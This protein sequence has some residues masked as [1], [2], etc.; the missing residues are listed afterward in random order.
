MISRRGLFK[1]ATGSTFGVVLSDLFIDGR[2]T[3][4]PEAAI[5]SGWVG[6]SDPFGSGTEAHGATIYDLRK[7]EY[8]VTLLHAE[9]ETRYAVYLVELRPPEAPDGTPLDWDAWGGADTGALD[10]DDAKFLHLGDIRTNGRGDG[11]L[12]VDL[13]ESSSDL[14]ERFNMIGLYKGQ[15]ASGQTFEDVVLACN[16]DFY[17]VVSPS[18][19][20]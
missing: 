20:E 13:G 16:G 7:A 18:M 14:V 5:R 17:G 8:H 12:S 19:D 3:A 11:V 10:G 15:R 2:A 6:L 4:Q 1:V 9:P